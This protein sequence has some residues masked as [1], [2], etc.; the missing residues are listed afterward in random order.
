[1]PRKSS[2]AVI[3]GFTVKKITRIRHKD[4]NMSFR[5]REKSFLNR[6]HAGMVTLKHHRS[7]LR[8]DYTSFQADRKF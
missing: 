6:I 4:F 3:F 8:R 5:P 1:M 2:S 7:F